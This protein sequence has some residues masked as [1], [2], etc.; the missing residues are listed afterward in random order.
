[1]R[2]EQ[3]SNISPQG[4]FNGDLPWYKVSKITLNK[5]KWED[6]L[7]SRTVFVHQQFFQEDFYNYEIP[8]FNV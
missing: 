6:G 5:F 1:M 3:V 4:W 2:V 8:D 7:M